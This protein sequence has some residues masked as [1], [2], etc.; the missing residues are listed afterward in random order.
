MAIKNG[1]RT[2]TPIRRSLGAGDR[3]GISWY[4]K[5]DPDFQQ[6]TYSRCHRSLRRN[7]LAG[8]TLFFRALWRGKPYVIGYGVISEKS[9]PLD[10]PVCHLD[11]ALSHL[12]DFKLPI[13]ES[14]VLRLNPRAV[15]NPSLHFNSW[16]NACLS[17]N[18]LCLHQGPTCGKRE[19]YLM[20]RVLAHVR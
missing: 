1:K 10:N 5:P 19:R 17:R 6:L 14:M 2:D 11:P 4:R 18:Y 15:Q 3:E 20:N 13:T 8:D 7:L 9:G 16:V 12:I